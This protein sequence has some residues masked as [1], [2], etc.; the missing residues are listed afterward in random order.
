MKPL[1]P[2][3]THPGP[4]VYKRDSLKGSKHGNTAFVRLPHSYSAS[5]LFQVLLRVLGI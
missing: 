3:D 4:T 2:A 1:I 5:T